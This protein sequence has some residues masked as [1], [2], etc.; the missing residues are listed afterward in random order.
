MVQSEYQYRPM[1]QGEEEIMRIY[2]DK[3]YG[4]PDMSKKPG[5]LHIEGHIIRDGRS[6]SLQ[7]AAHHPVME[8]YS[9]LEL[10]GLLRDTPEPRYTPVPTP[11][12]EF[13]LTPGRSCYDFNKSSQCISW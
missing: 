5:G 4:P 8:A 7:A 6:C 13:P 10:E 12:L 11:D 2:E 3:I 9:D 1:A